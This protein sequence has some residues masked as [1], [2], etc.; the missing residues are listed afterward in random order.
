MTR[1]LKDVLECFK[2]DNYK[3]INK[4]FKT[5]N[6]IIFVNHLVYIQGI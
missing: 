1:N 4:Y 6:V 5:M 2:T 3:N